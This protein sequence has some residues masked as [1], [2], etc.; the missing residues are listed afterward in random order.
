ML[1]RFGET[2]AWWIDV[3]KLFKYQ[4]F[5]PI[6]HSTTRWPVDCPFLTGRATDNHDAF[7]AALCPG[8]RWDVDRRKPLLSFQRMSVGSP[9]E[10]CP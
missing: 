6:H 7:V 5:T 4:R 1:D 3:S 8:S 9:P 10:E 2:L